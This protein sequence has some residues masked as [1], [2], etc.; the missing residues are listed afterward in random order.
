MSKILDEKIEKMT[1]KEREL[2]ALRHTAE[3]V[4]HTAMQNLYP[5]LKKA[6]GPATADGFYH[7]FDLAEKV[8]GADF[9]KIE[10]EMQR[11]IDADLPLA[12]KYIS[13][14]EAKKLFADNPYKLEWVD[15][16]EKRG[17][18]I[19]TYK[20]GEA[21]LDVCSGPHAAST[22][23]IGA[24]KLLSIAGAYW[25]GSE[26]NKMLTRIYG[27][28]FPTQKELEACLN[29]VEE[30]KKRDH[31]KIGQ[32]QELFLISQDVGPGLPIYM[33]KGLLLRRALEQWIV[34]EK[35]KR[36]YKFV[37]TPHIAKSDLY[38]KSKHWQ[39]YE[40][41]FSPM[42]IDKEEYV[43][44][45]MNCPHHFQ[46]Y[47]ERIRSY[48]EL[49]LRIAENAT[50]YRYE[51]A[52]ELNGLLRVRSL[53][54]DDT[55]TFVREKQIPDEIEK[56]LELATHIFSTFNFSHIKAR[57]STRDKKHPE[58]YLGDSASWDKAEAAL[59][60]AIKK[61]GMSNFIEEGEAAFY[62]PKIDIMVD[63]ALGREWQL[64]TVQLDF[65]QPINFDMKYINEE[66][67]EE[68][69]AV[70]HI[71]ILG[72]FERFIAIL[73]EHFAGAFPVWLSPVQVKILPIADRHLE[74][75]QKILAQLLAK[76]I[77]AEVDDRPETVSAKIRDA[78][79][80]KIPY[81]L[82]IGDREVKDNS[83]SVRVR[84]EKN[85][86]SMPLTKLIDLVAEDIEKKRQI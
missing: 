24:F 78:E 20:M 15:L 43:V 66:G 40:A 59:A 73:I 19:S 42:K 26:K 47:L 28:A 33:P 63:D 31:K 76:N 11:L 13:P 5:Q 69:P 35:E 58:K 18:K 12:Q 36:G 16:I 29:L 9:P 45:P 65:N 32:E 39:K 23:K 64:T 2:W 81:M 25:H 72:S 14:K 57:V 22:G 84:G 56:I 85:L 61:S 10:K 53:T 55:H 17:E 83:V 54:Q 70:L 6:M 8:S 80:Q 21:D 1:P 52:G 77:R 49:P 4:L 44:K 67:R 74:P 60:A 71:A 46:I 38:K 79:M 62:G 51:K 37:W 82:I 27:T 41:M 75:C 86:G 68:R 30:A 50:V 3:H 48:K 34:C 7:D